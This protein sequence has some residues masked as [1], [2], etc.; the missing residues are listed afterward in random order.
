MKNSKKSVIITRMKEKKRKI[1]CIVGATASGKTA[2]GVEIAKRFNGEI[3]SADSRQVFCRLDIGT[4]KEG[5]FAQGTD[6]LEFKINNLKINI[7]SKLK[8]EN[9]K[10]QRRFIEGVPQWLIDICLPEQDFSMFDWLELAKV[11]LDDIWSRG[12]TPIVVGGTGL[13][14][15]ALVQGFTITNNV[16]PKTQNQYSREELNSYDLEKLQ[17]IANDLVASSYQLESV[18]INNPRRLIRLIEREQEGEQPT[19]VIPDFE[20]LLIGKDLPREELYQKID[21][22]VDEWFKE[23]FYE[24]VEGLLESGVSLE[25]LDKIGLEYRILANYITNKELN[26]KD[27]DHKYCCNGSKEKQSHNMKEFEEMK[28]EMKWKIH[29]YARRQLIWWRRFDVEWVKGKDEAYNLC[30]KLLTDS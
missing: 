13:Y 30:A 1:V 28:Q 27:K 3:V 9:L 8:I 29:Q 2:L 15:Q 20:Y 14:V 4:G 17:S 7:N 12:R 11:V 19:K 10:R 24:E 6:N 18:D 25:W 21:K 26:I 22:R 23:G 16:K 5:K